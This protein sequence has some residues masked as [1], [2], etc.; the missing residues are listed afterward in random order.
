VADYRLQTLLD[1]RSRAEEEAK[2]AFARALKALAEAKQELKR[3]E[4][5]L[6]RRKAERSRKVKAYLEELMAKGGAALAVQAMGAYEKRLRGEEDEVAAQIERQKQAVQEAE[7]ESE[8]KRLELAEAAKEKK[9]I[10]KH[11]E[12]WAEN[13]KRERATREEQA[14]EEIGNAL[15][16]ASK[17]KP[18]DG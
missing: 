12:D 2:E 7:A 17:R 14:A 3:L 15:Y 5:D 1:L 18:G 6:V 11:K 4:D 8:R 13:L 16:L 10:E 9:A